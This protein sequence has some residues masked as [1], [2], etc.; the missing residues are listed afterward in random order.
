MADHRSRGLGRLARARPAPIRTAAIT[1]SADRGVRSGPAASSDGAR[2]RRA[3]SSFGLPSAKNAD[4]SRVVPISS[5][6]SDALTRGHRVDRRAGQQ[7]AVD[8]RRH[9]QAGVAATGHVSRTR[10]PPATSRSAGTCGQRGPGTG[11][12]EVGGHPLGPLGGDV[13]GR[14]VGRSALHDGPVEQSGGGRRGQERG[15]AHPAGRLAEE[16]DVPGVAAEVGDVVADPGRGRPPDRPGPSCRCR[17]T[18]RPSSQV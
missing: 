10:R 3:T 12:T 2:R 5:G 8:H 4:S 15:D 6:T 14:R 1:A 9:Q 11:H 7:P 17:S 13:G 16:G 18:R